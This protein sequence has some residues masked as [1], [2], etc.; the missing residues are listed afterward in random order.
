MRPGVR[1][2]VDVG[3]ARIGIAKCDQQGMLATPVETVARGH[4]DL[5]RIAGIAADIGAI[6][7]VV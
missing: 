6:E 4:G 5:A 3:K 7:I 2:G 1:V